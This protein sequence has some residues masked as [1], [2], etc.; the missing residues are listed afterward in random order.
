MLWITFANEALQ[1]IY[2][3]RWLIILCVICII[4]DLWWSYAEHVYHIVHNGHE[5]AWRTSKAVRK[6]ALKFVDYVTF[7]LVGVVLGLAICEPLNVCSHTTAAI[8]GGLIGV[9]CDV[10]SIISHVIVVKEIPIQQN[11]VRKFFIALVRKKNKD[12][13][14]ALDETI[15]DKNNE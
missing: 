2:D 9:G 5:D 11:F 7:L 6:S 1:A 4:A 3:C 8:F 13:G 15:N 12:I 10:K 14:D